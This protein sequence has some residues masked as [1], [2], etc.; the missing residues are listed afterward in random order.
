MSRTSSSSRGYGHRWQK[1]RATFL[2]A[3][4]LCTYCKAQGLLTPATVV[5]HI[6]PHRGDQKLFWD[7]SNWQG[8]CKLHHDSTKQR[9]ELG[10]TVNQV[11][12]DGFPVGPGHHWT[13]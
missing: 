6:V 4:P 12:L 5:D 7:S 3:H 11:G 9:E 10:A 13:T 2:K 8:L 1:A